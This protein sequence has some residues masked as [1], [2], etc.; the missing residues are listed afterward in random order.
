[1]IHNVYPKMYLPLDNPERP[2]PI[3]IRQTIRSL[4]VPYMDF[5]G[6]ERTGTIE[7]HIDLLD[8]TAAFFECALEMGFPIERLGLAGEPGMDWDDDKLMAANVSSG[9]NFRYIAGTERIS[10]HAGRAFDVNPRQ[11]PYIRYTEQGPIVAPEGA[12]WD[13]NVPGTL[14]A[15]H[16]LVRMMESRGWEWGGH[17]PPHSGRTDFQHFQKPE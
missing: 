15:G 13:P 5:E 11:N 1:M 8:D 10:L 14:Y 6:T 17:W 2:A 9:Y 7:M 12:R 16:P 4:H 3:E